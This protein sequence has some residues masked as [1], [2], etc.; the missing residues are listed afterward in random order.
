MTDTRTPKSFFLFG[1][2]LL[3]AIVLAVTGCEAKHGQ[4]AAAPATAATSS[5][6]AAAGDPI[7]EAHERG[8]QWA[9]REDAKLV[10]D[11]G[12]LDNGDER[13]G[14]ADYINHLPH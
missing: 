11:C 14:C 1:L 4:D 13:F 7:A 3:T 5:G 2:L 12:A 9:M 6:Q 10:T 8:R